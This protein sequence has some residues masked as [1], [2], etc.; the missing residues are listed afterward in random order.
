MTPI[1]FS[2][3]DRERISREGVPLEKIREQMAL[4][5]DP[6][7]PRRLDRPCT[8][9]D[10]ILVFSGAEERELLECFEDRQGDLRSVKFVPASGAATRMFRDWFRNYQDEGF[11]RTGEGRDFSRRLPLYPFYGDLS[12]VME[13]AG[14]PLDVLVREGKYR[15]ILGYVLTERGL[16][17]AH[18]PKALLKF[19]TCGTHAR[20]SL[21]EHLVEAA[22]YVRDGNDVCA[23]HFTVSGEHEAQVREAVGGV[24]RKYE[25]LLGVRY[26]WSVSVQS[27][28][29]NTIAVDLDDEPFRDDGGDLLFRPGGHGALLANLNRLDGDVVFLKNIDN[30]VPDRLKEDTIRYKKI[31]GGCLLRVRERVF[32]FLRLLKREEPTD[33]LL[34]EIAR[35]C[36]GELF[37]DLPRAFS[38][39]QRKEKAEILF[40]TLNRPIRVCGMV[41]N[42]GEPGGG[43]FWVTGEDGRR[44]LQ[45]V[46]EVEIDGGSEG[47]RAVW[48]SS[49]H[50]NP[51]D[52]ACAVRDYRG[53]KFD[54]ER[55]AD[56]RAV[57]ISRKSHEGR[58]LKAL[59]LP[60]LWNGGMARWTTLFAEVP[61]ITFNP[62]K[63]V[64]DLLRPEH[65]EK[66]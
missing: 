32:R 26:D 66:A 29:T 54:L 51:V 46:E 13:R 11:D 19:H 33:A 22:G 14:R 63:T 44:S 28:A 47:Q 64:D 9:G 27:P 30:V 50:F 39:A 3:R 6:P 55:F 17:Y 52:L 62:V 15:E 36:G 21:E 4:F 23:L 37:L 20:T 10:G 35:F 40:E 16:D 41:K 57:I 18:L 24:V 2:A 48:K 5:R 59:E 45:I 1:E 7:G 38:T 8:A 53:E 31:L 60:G 49:T 65:R 34:G 43:P 61:I 58:D 56:P 42:E 12:S 25:S